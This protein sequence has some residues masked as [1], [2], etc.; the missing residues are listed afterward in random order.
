MS[1]DGIYETHE[2]RD[3]LMEEVQSSK[4]TN[5]IQRNSDRGNTQDDAPPDDM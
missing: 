5:Q 4:K 1:D 2:M 3:E